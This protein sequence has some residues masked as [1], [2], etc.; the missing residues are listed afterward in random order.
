MSPRRPPSPLCWP[1]AASLCLLL[2]LL[3][4]GSAVA[5]PLLRGLDGAVRDLWNTGNGL[6]HN[7]V[8]ALAQSADGYLWVA[9]WEGLVRYNGSEFAAFDRRSVPGWPD[10][11]VRALLVAAD[12]ALWV[13]TARGGLA[14]LHR[15]EWSFPAPARGLVTDLLQDRAGR[16]WIATEAH[17]VERIDPA[18]GRQI[19]DQR[20]G[21]P[22]MA[23]FTLHEAA[24]GRIYAGTAAGIARL[25][26]RAATAVSAAAGMPGETV[27]ALDDDGA[28]GL[29]LGS[30]S[31]AWQLGADGVA[32]PI[33]LPVAMSVSRVLQRPGG[34][35]YFGSVQDGLFRHWQGRWEQLGT[36]DGLPNQRISA[37]LHDREGNLW[38][39]SNRGLV[40]LRDAPLRSLT[41]RHGLSDDFVR[42]VLPDAD[43]TLWV[44]T[45]LGLNRIHNGAV[46]NPPALQAL[47]GESILAL[48]HAD[49]GGL[50]VGTFASGLLR[51][52]GERIVQR[53]NREHGLASNE[54]RVVLDEGRHGLWAGST[55]GLTHFAPE[56]TRRYGVEEGLPGHFI[57][58]LVRS[59]DGSLWVA[60]ATGLGRIRDGRAET[61]DLTA[62]GGAEFI[63]GMLY[64]SSRQRLWLA[65]DRGLLHYRS[66]D[67]RWSQLSLAQGLPVEKVFQPVL[68]SRGALW[69]SSNRG[70]IRIAPGSVDA[71]LEGRSAK[72]DAVLLGESDGMASAQCN[73]GSSPAAALAGDGT[74]WFATALGVAG[75]PPDA[76]LSY[77]DT[78]P[79]AAIESLQADGNPLSP[80]HEQLL[81][82]GTRRI[83]LTFAGPSFLTPEW[84]RYRTRL[85]GFDA[86]WVDRGTLRVAEYTN[87]PPGDYRFEVQAAN[88]DSGWS[89][90][91]ATVEFHIAAQFWQQRVF[92]VLLALASLL[93]AW[94]GIRWRFRRLHARERELRL[95]VD[96]RT[97]D[98][99]QQTERLLALGAEREQLVG[100]LREQAEAFERQAREDGLT[101]LLNRR[102]FDEALQAAVTASADASV[103]L[104]LAVIDLDNFK[105]VND[106]HSHAAGDSVLRVVAGLLAAGLP[107]NARLARWGGE[108]FALLLPG[109]DLDAAWQRCETLRATVAD[110]DA[111]AISPGLTLSFSA[112][113]AVRQ[114][115]ERS[116][117]LLQR[118]DT[119]LYRAKAAGRNRVERAV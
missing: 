37:L 106:R 13:G 98:L 84:V 105:L 109:H 15:G 17:G 14:R 114:P 82:A 12:G 24:D 99:Q 100:R 116:G 33:E 18:G 90:Q 32:R 45:S 119:A 91:P 112:G 26:E 78:P 4:A 35:R 56:G 66:A 70:V 108:E 87:L 36:A 110:Y 60:T 46:D 62:F 61:V 77:A 92:W 71:V 30:E 59:S 51:L 39:G 38:L 96:A 19:I 76:L 69:L 104:A 42:S 5:A 111:S 53:L 9:T 49:A 103:P 73:G 55:L 65:T 23:V 27:F 10:D 3:A 40:R 34:E 95:L 115:G 1:R 8:N 102:G 72:L 7:T 118:A 75:A 47:A 89:A 20:H 44:G 29:L 107:G 74:V 101:G 50:W 81:P 28:G 41:R 113:V 80:Y 22:A 85:L 48:A 21:L 67:A 16:I 6:P 94:A 117:G 43:G 2:A 54:V 57:S 63:F 25:D 11:G 58:G 68:D 86:E 31:G 79:T 64:D 97:R 52:D 88:P 93:L 83:A